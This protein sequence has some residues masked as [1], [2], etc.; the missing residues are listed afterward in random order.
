MNIADESSQNTGPTSSDG[1]TCGRSRKAKSKDRMLSREGS[2]AK[3]SATPENALG[4]KASEAV[5]G[6]SSIGS[7]AF[8]DLDSFSW[9]TWQRCLDGELSEFLE[10]W[11]N[12]G[13]TRNGIAFPLPPSV[14]FISG[15]GSFFWPTPHSSEPGEP[16]EKLFNR[17]KRYGRTGSQVHMHLSTAVQMNYLPT[18][19][20]ND[21]KNS[22]FPPSLRGRDSL[23]GAMMTTPSAD[24]T[25]HR[26]KPYSQGGEALSYQIGGQLNPA[27]VEWLMGFP[28]G[29]TDLEDSEIASSP[30]SPNG[31]DAA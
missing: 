19:T 24:D 10:T 28:P 14:P 9:R 23:I 15:I 8:F 31:S 11:P 27:W 12:A 21:A 25:G 2:R 4:L 17:M 7:F 18:P 30:K 1:M 6:P 20:A 26:K 3:T 5:Y 22:T 29:F 16:P 13:M